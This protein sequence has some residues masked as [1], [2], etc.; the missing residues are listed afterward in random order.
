ML[1]GRGSDPGLDV[2]ALK[3]FTKVVELGSITRAATQLHIA[4]PALSRQIRNLEEELG[5][6]LMIRESRGVRLTEHGQLL[7]E[8]AQA[9][10]R[11]VQR[12][13]DELRGSAASPSGTVAVGLVPTLCPV[14]AP[15]LFATLRATYPKIELTISENPT[16]PLLD[17]LGEGRIDLAILTEPAPTRRFVAERLVEEEMILV[18]K[19]ADGAAPISLDRLAET[20]VIVSGGVRVIMDGLLARSGILLATLLEMN[21]VETIRLMALEGIGPAILPY[22]IVGRDVARGD[23]T[24]HPIGDGLYRPLAIAS[25]R[26]RRLSTAAQVVKDVMGQVTRRL[27]RDG[28]FRTVPH[29]A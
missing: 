10:L 17:W 11:D 19:L 20:P 9:I 27:D 23:L 1:P 8:R 4:Q 24:A 3:Y 2:R 18:T 7:F 5:I 25:A 16:G 28:T 12:T 15:P 29:R 6:A 26:A 14:I 22:A 13:R 21:S